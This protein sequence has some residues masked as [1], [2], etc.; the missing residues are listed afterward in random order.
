MRWN[1]ML[2]LPLNGEQLPRQIWLTPEAQAQWRVERLVLQPQADNRTGLVVH[3]LDSGVP[4]TPESQPVLLRQEEKRLWQQLPELLNPW[5]ELKSACEQA[6]SLGVMRWGASQPLDHG[7]YPVHR[8]LGV[9]YLAPP[10]VAG[11]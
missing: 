2:D 9:A 1:L 5:P 6:E 10:R 11:I 8:A 7:L 4:I 3:G